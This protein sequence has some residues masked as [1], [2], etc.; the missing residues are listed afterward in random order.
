MNERRGARLADELERRGLAAP[1]RLLLDAHRP[2]RPFLADMATVV[3]PLLGPLLGDRLGDVRRS[4][5]DD[6]GYDAL[7]AEVDGHPSGQ[8]R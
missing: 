8:G 5:A 4:L 7:L 1:A 6:D 2:L 3:G